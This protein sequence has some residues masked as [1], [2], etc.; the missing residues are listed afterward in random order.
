MAATSDKRTNRT[1]RTSRT[2]RTNSINTKTEIL[3]A[4]EIAELGPVQRKTEKMVKKR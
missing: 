4:K 1:N 2:N 3:L